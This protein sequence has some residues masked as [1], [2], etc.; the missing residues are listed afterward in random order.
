[1]PRHQ[2]KSD[3]GTRAS[4]IYSGA[5]APGLT[6]APGAVAVGSDVL[7]FSGAGRLSTVVMHQVLASGV[8]IN[9]YDAVAPISGGPLY[10]SGH[11]PMAFIPGNLGLGTFASGT[12]IP[13]SPSPGA[14]IFNTPFTKGLCVNSRSGQPG[15]TV[16]F[17]PDQ[18]V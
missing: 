11:I 14:F 13:T 5:N 7:L 16:T 4:A 12:A 8:A 10:T 17:S 6:C 1:M 3:A 2:L 18:K 9:F 15:F